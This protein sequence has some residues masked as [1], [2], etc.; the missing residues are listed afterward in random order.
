MN[1]VS[2]IA[3]LMLV[4]LQFKIHDNQIYF[5]CYEKKQQII[6]KI[7][8][9][10]CVKML[11]GSIRSS[12]SDAINVFL[13]SWFIHHPTSPDCNNTPRK[14]YSFVTFLI[15]F[16][17]TFFVS[18]KPFIWYPNRRVGGYPS[19]YLFFKQ[20]YS[21]IPHIEIHYGV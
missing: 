8:K 10:D 19:L 6:I 14:E 13:N 4:L 21:F 9:P 2:E 15:S 3:K 11:K 12:W 16:L 17:G 1:T 7:Q 18:S 20:T 5:R